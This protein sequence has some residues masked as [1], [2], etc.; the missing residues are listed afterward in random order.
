MVGGSSSLLLLCRPDKECSLKVLW[1]TKQLGHLPMVR[2]ELL[3]PKGYGGET[4]LQWS[5]IG[6]EPAMPIYLVHPGSTS[7]ATSIKT[8]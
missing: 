1:N 6:P 7:L 8:G 2:G 4:S 5:L 3:I